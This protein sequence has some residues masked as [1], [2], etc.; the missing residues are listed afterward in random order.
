MAMSM[1]Q[2][3][4]FMKK[5]HGTTKEVISLA[6]NT[7]GE[8]AGVILADGEVEPLFDKDLKQLRDFVKGES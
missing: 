1:D 3:S 4:G 2:I 5:N 7:S 8:I 6:F